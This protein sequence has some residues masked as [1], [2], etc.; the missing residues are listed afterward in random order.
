MKRPYSKDLIALDRIGCIWGILE[1]LLNLSVLAM[2]LA[3]SDGMA[4]KTLTY[5]IGDFKGFFINVLILKM[6]SSV[7]LALG[8]ILVSQLNSI[9]LA[10]IDIML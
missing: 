4:L 3:H 6:F 8:S 5:I 9:R 10:R 1:A 7:F 2:F